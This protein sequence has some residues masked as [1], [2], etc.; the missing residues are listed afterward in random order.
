M[1]KQFLITVE[2]V[3][4]KSPDAGAMLAALR[5]L[6]TLPIYGFSVATNPVAK[7]CMSALATCA[8]IRRQ[9]G[10]PATLHCTTRDH[11]RLSLQGLLWGARALE[12]DTALIMTGDFVALAD[13]DSTT[14]VRDIDVFDLVAL[15]REAGLRTGVVFAYSDK[16]TTRERAIRRLEKK[17]EAG[18]QFVVSQPVYDEQSVIA[19]SE[20]GNA[21]GIPMILGILPLRTLRH[22]EFLHNKVAGIE[23][24][25]TVRDQMEAASDP[26][27]EG[28]VNARQM[29]MLA[30][31]HVSG[32]CIMPPFNHY[33][34]VSEIFNFP[35]GGTHHG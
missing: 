32:V 11:N 6:S 26:V 14:T 31:R 7:P 17:V 3:P 30:Q 29:F 23:V 28:I 25:R 27:T 2:V 9:L 35:E 20:I 1:A 10:K 33:E 8:L 24:P 4:P 21:C 15:S 34:V 22:A 5:A 16:P 19:L 13:R 18:A 12:I